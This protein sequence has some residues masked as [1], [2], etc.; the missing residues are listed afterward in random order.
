M[1]YPFENDTSAV[2]KKLAARSMQA[3]KRNKA[4]LLLTIAISVCMVF[5]IYNVPI[6]VDNLI[7]VV[8]SS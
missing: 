6:T 1:N 2:I 7:S 8:P 3:D 4:F 5:S